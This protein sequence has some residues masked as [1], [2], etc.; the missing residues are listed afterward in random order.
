MALVNSMLCRGQ[1]LFKYTSTTPAFVESLL[2]SQA[3]SSAGSI[4]IFTVLKGVPLPL[5][6]SSPTLMVHST[7]CEKLSDVGIVSMK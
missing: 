5:T 7:F 4:Q 3:L 1:G 2:V 6:C